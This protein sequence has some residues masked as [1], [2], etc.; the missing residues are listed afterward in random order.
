MGVRNYVDGQYVEGFSANG[1]FTSDSTRDGF[2]YLGAKS[3]ATWARFRGALDEVKVFDQAL[4]V[5]QIRATMRAD[6]G[7]ARVLPAGGA[8]TVAEGATL[9]VNGTDEEASHI[10][11]SGTLDLVSGRLALAG[12]NTFAGT[13]VGDGTLMLPA[14]ADLTLGAD[15]AGFTGYFEMA[16]GALA[17]PEGV[18]RVNAT[19]RATAIDGAAQ[20]SYPGDVEIPDGT[21]LTLTAANKGP[22][23]TANGTV[24][25]LGSGTITLP[26]PQAVGN[27]E[28]A[29]GTAVVDAGSG[30]LNGRWSV[31]NAWETH[32]VKFAVSSGAFW[33]RVYGSGSLFFVR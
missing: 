25:I 32:T 17:L 3:T 24:T 2:F 20:V 5:H 14:G 4:S 16:G 30:D 11:G 19:F 18:T 26:D 10:S 1:A 27:W 9:E 29:R 23:I 8:V 7:G 13:L 31:A 15:P 22:L 21:A 6:A 12:T 33:C 28:I